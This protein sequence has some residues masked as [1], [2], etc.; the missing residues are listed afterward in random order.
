M[1]SSKGKG[2][3]LDDVET[4][5]QEKIDEFE[6]LNNGDLRQTHEAQTKNLMLAHQI[7]PLIL[8][9][10][11][12]TSPKLVPKQSP[13]EAEVPSQEA[14]AQRNSEMEELQ[15]SFRK[16]HIPEELLDILKGPEPRRSV[17]LKIKG[18][19][20]SSMSSS[21][22]YLSNILGSCPLLDSFSFHR[23]SID[24]I[25]EL[26][27]S[28]HV[29]LGD[30]DTHRK[31]IVDHLKNLPR[32]SYDSIVSQMLHKCKENSYELITIY[33]VTEEGKLVII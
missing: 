5:Q 4:M 24:E 29:I 20:R 25:S 15:V 26:F 21:K 33:P 16:N 3:V 28:Y 6:V 2:A 7:N 17:R 31:L 12:L 14:D 13:V 32:D 1:D 23:L 18:L 30:N 11:T 8:T 19:S 9:K 22:G 27:R 10:P